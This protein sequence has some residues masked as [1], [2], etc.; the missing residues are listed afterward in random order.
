M[1]TENAVKMAFMMP[2]FLCYQKRVVPSVSGLFFA[3]KFRVHSPD[4]LRGTAVG[5]AAV[6]QMHMD[7]WGIYVSGD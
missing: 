2:A 5:S 3:W 6:S 1:E 4:M 7:A